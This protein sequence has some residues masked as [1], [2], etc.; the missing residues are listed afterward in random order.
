MGNLAFWLEV[1][2]MY[3][4]IIRSVLERLYFFLT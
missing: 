4:K 1:E 3:Y 2:D